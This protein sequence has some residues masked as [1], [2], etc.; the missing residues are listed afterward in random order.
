MKSLQNKHKSY[1]SGQLRW[2]L[3]RGAVGGEDVIKGKVG[4]YK[5]SDFLPKFDSKSDPDC[6]RY[7]KY[8]ELAVYYNYTGWTQQGLSGAIF[9][10][11]P[12]VEVPDSLEYLF[13]NADG[14]EHGIEQVIKETVAENLTVG[15]VGAL[16]DVDNQQNAV[17]KLYVAE[18]I[19]DWHVDVIEGSSIL[20]YVRL[21]EK[22]EKVVDKHTRDYETQY[23]VLRIEKGYYVQEVYNEK[24]ELVETI[25]VTDYNGEKLD[26]IPFQFF[27]A[28]D[29]RP[30][31]D[32]P[33]LL[34]I[35]HVNLGHYRNSAD[36]KENLHYHGQG[37]LFVDIGDMDEEQFESANPNGIMIG[38]RAGHILG[39][40]G[41]AQLLQLEAAQALQDA[42]DKKVLQMIGIGARFIQSDIDAATA[43]GRLLD[44]AQQS[45]GLS[46]VVSNVVDGFYNVLRWCCQ[47]MNGNPD[48]IEFALNTDFFDK[49]YSAQEVSA[50]IMLRDSGIMAPEDVRHL[51]RAAGW[52]RP[53]RTDE[54]IET[55]SETSNDE[56]I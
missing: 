48:S 52:I 13:D 55:E 5:S 11:P 47:F 45:S 41:K 38:A 15:R 39:K 40:G 54:E 33:P 1:D 28:E 43:T 12:V 29:N 10:K 26:Y 25:E 50:M 9:R 23:R 3:M 36:Y 8:V 44:A 31:I 19:I 53:E 35:A 32:K 4:P 17:I 24:E 42:M 21:V 56:I 7:K 20:T 34:D 46:L 49:S 6:S 30:D 51:L 2:M 14:T 37:T 27:G 22:K 18:S 16:V